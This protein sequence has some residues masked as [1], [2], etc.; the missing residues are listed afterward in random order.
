MRIK[1]IHKIISF[2]Q[3]EIFKDHILHLIEIRNNST[4]EIF[5]KACKDL[6]NAIYGK[7]LQAILGKMIYILLTC[8]AKFQ[9][10]FVHRENMVNLTP[11][12]EETILIEKKPKI[13]KNNRPRS[14]GWAVLELAKARMFSFWYVCIFPTKLYLVFTGIALLGTKVH[15]EKLLIQLLEI[16]F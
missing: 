4:G 13:I 1:K 10:Y 16:K 14:I 15:F 5:K 9:K 3:K 2:T 12:N 6:V 8:E 11:I 7:V